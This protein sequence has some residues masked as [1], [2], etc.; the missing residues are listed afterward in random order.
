MNP[1]KKIAIL[2]LA[3]CLAAFFPSCESVRSTHIK[4]GKEYGVTKG[5]F[6]ARWWNYYERGRFLCRRGG[7]GEESAKDF[8]EAID[9]RSRDQRMAR[10]YGMHVV[11][12]FP[13]RE[14]GIVYYRMG[15]LEEA[16]KELTLSLS[17][18]PTSKTRFYLDRVKK[19]LME[20]EGGEVAPPRL[21]IDFPESY[22]WTRE[23]P[24][25]IS[26]TAEDDHL[27]SGVKIRGVPLFMEAA[28]QRIAF[29]ESLD[30]AQGEH[31][32][33]VEVK[34]LLGRSTNRSVVIHVDR[35][36]PLITVEDMN[37]NTVASGRPSTIRG[38]IYDA[39]GGI[40]TVCK[41]QG[42]DRSKRPGSPL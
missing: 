30:L 2:F 35:E 5:I 22:V 4:D 16:K 23:D 14:L 27:V 10:T 1:I 9:Q 33:L 37:V 28:Q 6:R 40:R 18:Y 26:G 24:V 25:I 42:R 41:R 8:R 31:T 12:Y 21:R 3:F 36:G 38:F 11:D 29:R 32:V 39:A 7:S 17:Q 15:N 13:H 20:K 19:S 34:N